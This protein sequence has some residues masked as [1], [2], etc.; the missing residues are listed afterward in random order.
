MSDV[1]PP[2][3]LNVFLPYEA[4]VDRLTSAA[5]Q[6]AG[7]SVLHRGSLAILRL[8]TG[9]PEV[10]LQG[11]LHASEW[12]GPAVVLQLMDELIRN[13]ALRGRATWYVLPVVDAEGYRRTWGGERFARTTANGVNANLNFPFR[14]GEAPPVLRRL[15]GAKLRQWM[16]PHPASV[17]CVKSLVDELKNLRN[18]QLFLDFHG[19][20]RLWL[21]PWCYSRHPSPHH[22]EHAALSA[23]AVAAANRV[24]GRSGYRAQAA[25]RTEVPL[26]GSCIDFVYGEIGCVHSYVVELPPSHPWGGVLRATLRDALRGDPKRWWRE[27]QSPDADV[28]IQ[29]G[30]EMGAALTAVV[31]H[32]FG[33]RL[34]P[35]SS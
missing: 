33:A 31:D 1:R 16:G 25:A 24:A 18:L 2:K 28:G 9:S 26:G 15:L 4:V 12:I 35:S 11:G 29:A 21:Y 14:W 34:S 27:G 19:F 30:K 8:G 32:L 20:G 17:S 13:S 5:Q 22:T 10:W 6:I 3:C 23:T 7:A